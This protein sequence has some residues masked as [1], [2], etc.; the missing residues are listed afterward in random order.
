MNNFH[1]FFSRAD[2]L[3]LKIFEG[4]NSHKWMTIFLYIDLNWIFDRGGGTSHK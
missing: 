1:C 3:K 4:E 2:K